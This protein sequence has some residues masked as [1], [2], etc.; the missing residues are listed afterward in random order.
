MRSRVAVYVRFLTTF[1]VLGTLGVG[2]TLYVLIHQRVRLPFET[3]YTINA[4][5][6]SANGVA[7]GVGQP[8]NVVGVHVGQVT[9]VKLLDGA[10]IVSMQLQVHALSQVFANATASLVP[11]TPLDDLEIELNPGGRPA[12]PLTPGSTIGLARTTAPVPLSDLMSTL[13]GDTRDYLASL[14]TSLAQGT[15]DRGPDMRRMLLALGPTTNQIGEITRALARRRTALAQFVHALAAVTRAASQDGQLASVVSAGDQTLHAIAAQDQPLRQA[16]AEL[17]ATLQTTRSTL[18]NLTPFAD[19]LGPTLKALLPAVRRLPK[20]LNALRPFAYAAVHT[21]GPD[22]EPLITAAE[23]LLRAAAP[24]VTNL[25]QASP[26][27]I[28]SAQTLNYFLNELAYNP[29]NQVNG[30]PDEGFLFWLDWAA[31]NM[32]TAWSTADANGSI[33]RATALVVCQGALETQVISKVLGVAG[34]CPK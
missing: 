24:A 13:D 25:N 27:L 1:V 31:H 23:P 20:V 32:D 12:A 8:V 28:G 3:V 14:I 11:I 5:F 30:S 10:A 16:I 21:I 26:G 33:W 15:S 7:P 17:P 4:A 9:G 34:L 19:Q 6:S 18:A 22:V 29:N 2:A